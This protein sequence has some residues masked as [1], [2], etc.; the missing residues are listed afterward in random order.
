MDR[1]HL[2]AK[3]VDFRQ[4]CQENGFPLEDFCLMPAY[5][6]DVSSSYVIQVKGSWVDEMLCSDALDPLFDYLFATT[7]EDTRR[8]I[9]SI[10]ILDSKE[11][12]HCERKT[13]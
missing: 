13:A 7:D 1:K 3:L 2:E 8:H 11:E 10:S 4:K 12:L 5:E 6:G 9:F